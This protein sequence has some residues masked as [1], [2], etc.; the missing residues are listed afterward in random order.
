MDEGENNH[1]SQ[2]YPEADPKNLAKVLNDWTEDEI[3][4]T[5]H[6]EKAGHASQVLWVGTTK[7]GCG[8]ST[9]TCSDGWKAAVSVCRYFPAGNY[10][11]DGHD[12]D[13]V[14]KNTMTVDSDAAMKSNSVVDQCLKTEVSNYS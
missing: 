2:S 11:C 9:G 5:A 10:N 1:I 14:K 8:Y 12:I 6:P 7:I 4:D 3:A 13:C